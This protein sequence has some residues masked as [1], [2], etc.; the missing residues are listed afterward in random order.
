MPGGLGSS[1]SV[2]LMTKRD[3]DGNE[4]TL[5]QWSDLWADMSY[6]L[7]SEDLVRDVRVRTMWEG[8]DDLGGAMFCVG[9][10]QGTGAFVTVAEPATQES[11]QQTHARVVTI[12]A[13]ADSTDLLRHIT[14]QLVA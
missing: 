3:R 14:A 7:L 11:A 5:L 12:V 1:V 2:P 9:V 8:V 4:V 10:Q 6:R 13:D